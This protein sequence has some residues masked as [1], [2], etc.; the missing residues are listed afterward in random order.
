MLMA[1]NQNVK[2]LEVPG[3]QV[4]YKGVA[5]DACPFQMRSATYSRRCSAGVEYSQDDEQ[6]EG[7]IASVEMFRSVNVCLREKQRGSDAGKTE[8]TRTPRR[9]SKHDDNV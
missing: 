6:R 9:P 3:W 7:R 5:Q 1:T 4:R 2:A 8:S